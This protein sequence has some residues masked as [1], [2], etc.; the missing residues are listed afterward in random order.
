[1]GRIMYIFK[2]TTKIVYQK[3]NT[4]PSA[5]EKPYLY[6][7]EEPNFSYLTLDEMDHIE[8]KA[9]EIVDK[10]LNEKAKR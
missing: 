6:E 9:R 10:I 2:Y 8:E 5:K 7:V 4:K 3:L 1:M